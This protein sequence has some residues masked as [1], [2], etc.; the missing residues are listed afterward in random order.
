[1]GPYRSLKGFM[2]PCESSCVLMGLY[3]SYLVL[4]DPSRSL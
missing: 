1:M 2:G 4:I 3:R